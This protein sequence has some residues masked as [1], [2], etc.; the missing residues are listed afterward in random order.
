MASNTYGNV[1]E[2]KEN[3][4]IYIYKECVRSITILNY[5]TS[6][7]SQKYQFGGSCDVF[8]SLWEIVCNFIVPTSIKE[9][10][11]KQFLIH[12]AV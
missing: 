12:T 8:F 4:T 3:C 2:A 7:V 11:F 1:G 10:L 5:N 9:V 6:F